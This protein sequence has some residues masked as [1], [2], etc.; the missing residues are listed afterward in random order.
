MP[1]NST[2][3]LVRSGGR[4]CGLPL[5]HVIETCRPQ[6]VQPL[7]DAP[8]YVL[9]LAR[10]R[11]QIIPVVDLA[12]ILGDKAGHSP[13]RFVSLRISDRRIA[14]AVDE[15]K[16][17]VRVPAQSREALPLLLKEGS[18]VVESMA[19]LDHS[20]LLILRMSRLLPAAGRE[21]S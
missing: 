2:F 7:G 9:G 19:D 20:L 17:L 8:A 14:L 1:V 5:D 21:P 11:G 13:T 15:V 10:V 12:A 18:P 6:P 16:G 3:L 4:Y